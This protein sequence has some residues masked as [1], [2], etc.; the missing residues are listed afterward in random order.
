MTVRV[1][2]AL[3]SADVSVGVSEE[4]TIYTRVHSAWSGQGDVGFGARHHGQKD[5]QGIAP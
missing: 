2:S 3:T 1:Q 5:M 4:H